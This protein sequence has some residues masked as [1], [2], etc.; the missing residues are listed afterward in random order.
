MLTVPE[1]QE[2]VQATFMK[3]VERQTSWG[4]EQLK[5]MF[6]ETIIEANNIMLKEWYRRAG[7]GDKK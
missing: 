3:N 4:K 6:M 5:V 7:G 2:I 1:Y